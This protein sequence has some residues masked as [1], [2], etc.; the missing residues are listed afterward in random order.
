MKDITYNKEILDLIKKLTKLTKQFRISKDEE[1]I[2]IRVNCEKSILVELVS[3]KK[4]FDFD[5]DLIGFVEGSYNK[6]YDFFSA[7]KN[8]TL[9]Q[10]E[11]K[12]II[13]D[14]NNN[15]KYSL[16]DPEIIKNSF[17][18]T[19]QLPKS[20]ASFKIT[21]DQFSYIKDMIH[22][23]GTDNVVFK[24]NGS[25]VTISVINN[26]S[27]NSYDMLLPLNNEIKDILEIPL[28][29]TIFESAPELEYEVNIIQNLF[30]FKSVDEN[31]TLNLYTGIKSGK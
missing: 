12:L 20:M 25:E 19:K 28:K 10:N 5:G 14:G 3:P 6:F 23:V 29:S 11:N 22:R 9:K 24:A 18:D 16:S 1:N 21:K 13:S 2:S 15:I 17:K 27:G 26:V 4:N 8:P 31:F 7:F 30:H